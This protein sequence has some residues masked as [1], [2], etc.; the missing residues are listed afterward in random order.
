MHLSLQTSLDLQSLFLFTGAIRPYSSCAVMI[1]Q[2]ILLARYIIL[3]IL[4]QMPQQFRHQQSQD[5]F[6]VPY[7]K[8]LYQSADCQAS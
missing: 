1:F 8:L 6:V 3:Q 5:F 4:L 2:A 7:G